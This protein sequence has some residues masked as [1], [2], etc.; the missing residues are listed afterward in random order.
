MYRLWIAISV[1]FG[2]ALLIAALLVPAHSR[3]IEAKALEVA[4]AHSPGLIEEGI[5]LVQMEKAG[6]ARMLLTAAQAENLQNADR[7]QTV[8]NDFNNEH[9]DL[10][11]WGG[12]DPSVER[13]EIPSLGVSRAYPVMDLL[14][15]RAVREKMLD[16]LRTR[17]RGRP[18]LNLFLNTR[19]LTNT[20][21]F[22]PASSASGQA[23]DG[24]VILTGLLYQ[25]DHFAPP[26]RETFEVLAAEAYKGDSK[27]LEALELRYLD[28]L[29]LGKRLDW[30]SL[31]ELVKKVNDLQTLSRLADA[32]R[33]HE[34]Q[35]AAVFAAILL[36]NQPKPVT[37]Y[38]DQYPETGINDLSFAA[39]NG[40]GGVE[41]LLK[42]QHRV[43]YPGKFKQSVISYDPFGAWFYALLPMGGQNP[44]GALLLKYVLLL[45]GSLFLAN[46]IGFAAGRT[47]WFGLRLGADTIFAFAICFI[48]ALVSEPFI[49][50]PSQIHDLPI[51]FHLPVAGLAPGSTL[52]NLTRPLM[53]N[54]VSLLP[55]IIFFLLQA[56][57][58]VWCLS[59]LNEIRRTPLAARMK[60]RLL[61]NEDHLFDAGLYVGLLGTIIALILFFLGIP[62]FSVMS[63]YSSTSFGIIFV[64]ILK[65]FHIRPLR[66]KLI[67][68]S[69]V[70]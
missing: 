7:L 16:F 50:L 55:L 59:K 41:T 67:I 14:M 51:R 44:R 58:Y 34:E 61:E 68:E 8:V 38:M 43:Y 9:R 32:A 3:A 18:G 10:A 64:V 11:P 1:V 5:T 27:A 37:E 56:M 2:A 25:G 30:I 21:H 28:L 39:K 70:A 60:L 47:Q 49:G 65:I 4:G 40:V 17:A 26:L 46:A 23:F 45:L 36:S 31:V 42:Q 53:N 66:R 29:S 13:A 24:A 20:V 6:P 57:I 69:D 19:T 48:L 52:S 22:P 33:G 12:S 15:Q 63:A 54:N 35:F 62:K